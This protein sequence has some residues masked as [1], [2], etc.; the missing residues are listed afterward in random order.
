MKITRLVIKGHDPRKGDGTSR[1]EAVTWDQTKGGRIDIPYNQEQWSYVPQYVSIACVANTQYTVQVSGDAS[2]LMDGGELQVQDS[3]G[4]VVASVTVDP[5]TWDQT[6]AVFTPSAAA[7]YY[8]YVVYTGWGEGDTYIEVSVTPEPGSP[9]PTL[10]TDYATGAEKTTEGIVRP[11]AALPAVNCAAYS[12][13]AANAYMD[14]ITGATGSGQTAIIGHRVYNVAEGR[15]TAVSEASIKYVAMCSDRLILDDE[16]NIWYRKDD[17]LAYRCRI[18]GCVQFPDMADSRISC[19]NMLVDRGLTWVYT[20]DASY[21]SSYGSYFRKDAS[22]LRFRTTTSVY[23]YGGNISTT[24]R[25]LACGDDGNIYF[26]HVRDGIKVIDTSGQWTWASGGNGEEWKGLGIKAGAL[27]FID[28]G[29]WDDGTGQ[30]TEATLKL[31]D[32]QHTWKWCVCAGSMPAA[33]TTDGAL[34]W[35]RWGYYE[36]PYIVQV[37]ASGCTEAV[38]SNFTSSNSVLGYAIIS[39]G[40]YTITESEGVP[41]TNRVGSRS[42]WT[43]VFGGGDVNTSDTQ[44]KYGFAERDGKMYAIAGT[45]AYELPSFTELT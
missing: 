1:A 23:P 15:C 41:S 40:L 19:A 37:V 3:S 32:D 28:D 9:P 26:I 6:P 45:T 44:R 34:Y 10:F 27:Y 22:P 17:A 31:L 4:S 29:S 33:L 14:N 36:D 30:Q 13:H 21:G 8:L 39:G 11:A 43:H 20:G 24:A 12:P 2:W 18:G 38:S 42:D 25:G 5:G 7:T 35:V 16:C